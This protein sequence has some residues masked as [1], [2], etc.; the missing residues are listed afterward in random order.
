MA[1]HRSQGI[2]LVN[3]NNFVN[4]DKVLFM[5]AKSWG[6]GYH[7]EIGFDMEDFNWDHPLIL[8]ADDVSF[9]D[10]LD[11]FRRIGLNGEETGDIEYI[12]NNFKDMGFKG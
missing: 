10:T 9:E 7:V 12:T 2:F 8:G 4:D 6:D 1:G 5:Q 3:F 11:L